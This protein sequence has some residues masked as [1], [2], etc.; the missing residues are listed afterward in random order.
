MFCVSSKVKSRS[1]QYQNVQGETLRRHL[2][3]DALL[4][5]SSSFTCHLIFSGFERKVQLETNAALSVEMSFLNITSPCVT[6]LRSFSPRLQASASLVFSFF[7][8]LKTYIGLR[9]PGYQRLCR[10]GVFSGVYY[11]ATK[12]CLQCLA[13][14]EAMR[15][16][17]APLRL[18]ETLWNRSAVARCTKC[19]DFSSPST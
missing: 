7:F 3:C 9:Y 5:S 4:S 16:N 15:K 1:L 18:S 11:T 2:I 8:F 17:S 10:S 14:L 13:G 6:P 12:Q 19:Y